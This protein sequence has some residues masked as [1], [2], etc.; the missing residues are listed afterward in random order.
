[1]DALVTDAYRPLHLRVLAARLRPREGRPETLTRLA[2]DPATPAP[3][4]DALR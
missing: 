4:R 1:M 3:L 2:D